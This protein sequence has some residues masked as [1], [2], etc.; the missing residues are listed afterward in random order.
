MLDLQGGPEH[1]HGHPEPKERHCDRDHSHA[2]GGL[3]TQRSGQEGHFKL[4]PPESR[5]MWTRPRTAAVGV[6]R[7][8]NGE[9]EA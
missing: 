9:S 6:D 2:A 1:G 7:D 3:P 4:Q 8:E 5:V